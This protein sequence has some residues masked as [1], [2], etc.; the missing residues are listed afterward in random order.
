ML[1][2]REYVWHLSQGPFWPV[3]RGI[4]MLTLGG[5]LVGLARQSEAM[6]GPLD[7]MKK[8]SS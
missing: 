7:I 6:K 5:G 4:G 3:P 1:E 2:I 8:H